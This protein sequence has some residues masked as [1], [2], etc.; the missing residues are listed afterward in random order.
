SE[1]E[2]GALG[3]RS[4][5]RAEAREPER[6]VF[7]REGAVWRVDWHGADTTVNDSKG[8]GDIAILLARP[9]TEVDVLDLMGAGRGVL[10]DG[11]VGP[12]IDETAKRAYRQRLGD[13]DED[14]A[15]AETNADLGQLS[16][17]RE[18]RQFLLDELS[19]VLGLGGRPRVSGDQRERARKAVGMRIRTALKAIDAA[20]PALGRHLRNSIT[21][22]RFCR[23]RPEQPTTWTT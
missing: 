13:L 14:I 3:A 23:Y 18:E 12:L 15:D 4:P 11:G 9:G 22:G 21:T 8:M 7:R 1:A 17:L 19:A 5:A 16:A 10:V 20:H 2:L 6:A